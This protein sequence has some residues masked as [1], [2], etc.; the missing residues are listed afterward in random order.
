M[1]A[2]HSISG[3]TSARSKNPFAL[4]TR[5]RVEIKTREGF[6]LDA[7]G[8]IGCGVGESICGLTSTGRVWAN[9]RSKIDSAFNRDN[10]HYHG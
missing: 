2:N 3:E 10:R 4:K 7:I 8:D 9:M 5:A 1:F 6:F